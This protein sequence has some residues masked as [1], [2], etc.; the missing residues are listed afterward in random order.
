MRARNKL[1]SRQVAA[2][3]K[4]NVYS[5]GGGLYL[6]VRSS[7]TRSW[8]FVR[9]VNKRRR[10][11][12]LGSALDVSLAEARQKASKL[13]RIFREGRDPIAERRAEE[14]AALMAQTFGE[15]AE[16]YIARIVEGFRN[17]KHKAQW[18]STIR[19]YTQPLYA[20]PISAIDTK[21]VL[22]ILEP[23]WLEKPET[24]GRVRQRLERILD[25][26]GIEG[27]RDGD[28]P[29]RLKGNL[30]LLLPRQNKVPI[31]HGAMSYGDLP[32]F[33]AALRKRTGSS[34]RALEFAILTAARTGEVLGMTWAEVDVEAKLW[35]VPADRMKAKIEHQVP[36]SDAAIAILAA[37]KPDRLD[38]S[39]KIFHN[40]KGTMLS[41]MAMTTVLRRMNCLGVTVHG[42]RSTFRDWVGEETNC[43]REVA[44]MALAHQVGN[45]TERAYRRG[46][47]VEKRRGLMSE[48]AV[49][50][51][52]C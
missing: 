46:S 48:W 24:A 4:P 31:H 9:I 52:G 45:K 18:L 20:L 50:A 21:D 44:E 43:P 51:A 39:G 40:G 27:L 35:I 2:L 6:R 30:D 13:R 29:A 12:G 28:N 3:T 26:A 42:F 10:E 36:L 14:R 33:M 23:I 37:I 8:I 41:N 17:E 34:A 7:G 11:L 32:S 16:P 5:D 38:P 1:S 47:A 15:F 22:S 25:A 19:T 49:F